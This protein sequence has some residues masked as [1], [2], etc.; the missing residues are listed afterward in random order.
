LLLFN[1]PEGDLFNSRDKML[2]EAY[3]LQADRI[4]FVDKNTQQ[5]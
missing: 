4:A 1:L 2:E 3:N 5:V